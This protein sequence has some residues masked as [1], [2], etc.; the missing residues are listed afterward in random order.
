MTFA[1]PILAGI[2]AAI[3]V[4]ALIILYFLKLR[5]RD[6]EV[7][8]T[9]LWKKAIQDLQANAPFQKLRNNILLFLQLLILAAA[10]LA[11]GQP[12]LKDEGKTNARHIIIIDN[13]ASMNATDGEAAP[14]GSPA[15]TPGTSRLEVAK[16]DAIKLVEGLKEPGL[17][18]DKGEEAM[19]IAFNASAQVLQTF[20]TNKGDLKNAIESVK[21]TDAPGSLERCW[22]LAEAYTGKMKLEEDV[23]FV[24]VGPGATVHLH[25][26]GRLADAEKVQRGESDSILYHRVGEAEAPNV[27]ITG[28]RAE[29]AFDNPLRL[30]IFVG[31]Q[32]TDRAERSVDVELVIDGEVSN[33][34]DVTVAAAKLKEGLPPA[35]DGQPDPAQSGENWTPGLG[36]FV[37][38]IDRAEG[39]IATVRINSS[40]LD[41]LPT[42]NIGYVVIPPAKR[43]S[44]ALVSEGSLFIQSAFRGMKLSQLD[45]I[46][47]AD[48]QKLLDEGK[49]GQYDVFVFD[50]WLPEVKVNTSTAGAPSTTTPPAGTPA[51]TPPAT[52]PA[53]TATRTAGLPPGRSVV[54]GI[55]PP[56]PLGVTDLG[57]VAEGAVI[58]DYKRDHPAMA[59]SAID[60]INITKFR[61]VAIEPDT[62]VRAIA[63]SDKGPAV[64]EIS[65][66]SVL[67]IVV[68]WDVTDSD[69]C[70]DP[71]WVLFLAGSVLYLSDAGAG[72]TGESVRPGE[73]L[74]TRIPLGATEARVSLP[75]NSRVEVEP[76]SDGS[77]AFGP[78]VTSGIYTVSWAGAAAA[79]DFSAEGRVRRPIAANLTDPNESDIGAASTIDLANEQVAA[80]SDEESALTR[81]LWPYLLLAALAIIMLEWWVYNRK[82]AI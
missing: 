42:D 43:L 59:L 47:P 25:T 19:V 54:I 33:V 77:V 78:V 69:W 68:P 45:V 4:P 8:T 37:F 46:K 80:K 11:I 5:R 32:S 44:V 51:T 16:Q 66:S 35:E 39:G 71:G 81:K 21:P 60:R 38:P 23:G 12:E 27:G 53:P 24:P 73:T 41:S 52:A 13:S 48:F 61:K 17:F 55:P 62:P 7:S 40:G 20:T 10:L 31:L 15:G 6:M 75:D 58:V 36:G 63:N 76:A 2:A 22:A 18:D 30:S 57:P 14:S 50:R 79:A 1:T 70:F 28:L 64:V 82:V 72:A 67:A 74:R 49:T 56:P 26:D 29:R 65:D 3:A 9:L 34:R